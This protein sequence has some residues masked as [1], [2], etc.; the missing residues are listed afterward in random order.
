MSER[1]L[2]TDLYEIACGRETVFRHAPDAL[3]EAER[4]LLKAAQSPQD[5]YERMEGM[6]NAVLMNRMPDPDPRDVPHA[7][8]EPRG[9]TEGGEAQDVPYERWSA[10][11]MALHGLRLDGQQ[12]RLDVHQRLLADLDGRV[13]ALEQRASAAKLEGE[14]E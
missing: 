6:L 14:D 2:I 10:Q 7:P 5:P 12:T 3:A 4:Y 13:Q 1:E 9:G 8:Q 11:K